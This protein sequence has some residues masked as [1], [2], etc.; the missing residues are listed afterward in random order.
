MRKALGI[1]VWLVAVSPALAEE[2]K[3][4][5]RPP[6]IGKFDPAPDGRS[7]IVSD[8]FGGKFRLSFN[9]IC[10]G[11]GRNTAL[12]LRQKTPNGWACLRRN[13]DVISQ[14]AGSSFM[15]KCPINAIEAL[16]AGH[17]N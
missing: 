9:G 3:A 8:L 1:A 16:S 7:I 2:G 10:P 4:C 15:F 5:V 11:L 14:E 17:Q 12:Q 6:Q 13:D